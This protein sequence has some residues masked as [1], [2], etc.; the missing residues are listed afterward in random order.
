MFEGKVKMAIT[1]GAAT[2]SIEYLVKG[3][4]MRIETQD[5]RAQGG[6]MILNMREKKMLMLMPQQRLYVTMS[7]PEVDIDETADAAEKK[8][9]PT[10]ETRQIL[11]HTAQQYLME[12]EKTVYEIWATKELGTF[13]ALHLP[14]SEGPGTASPRDRALAGQDFFPLLIIERR[15]GREATRVE[16]TEVTPQ[17]LPASLFQAPEGFREMNLPF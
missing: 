10:G 17:E 7:L 3:D 13:G 11:G 9:Q 6:V 15:N 14:G 8:P 5:P 16:V 1:E 2:Q 12:D 4:Q